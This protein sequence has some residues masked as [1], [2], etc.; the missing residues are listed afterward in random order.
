M[1]EKSA[2]VARMLVHEF[3]GVV[4]PDRRKRCYDGVHCGIMHP[5]L[6][7]DMHG[8]LAQAAVDHDNIAA[9]Q[10]SEDPMQPLT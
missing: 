2:P 10:G 9:S 6:E 8:S 4:E 5:V 7:F 3:L 1:R